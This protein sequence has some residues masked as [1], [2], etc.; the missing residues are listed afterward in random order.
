MT[1]RWVKRSLAAMLFSLYVASASALVITKTNSDFL[2]VD[3]SSATASVDFL[4]ADFLGGLD[5]I[6]KVVILVDFAKCDDPALTATS[7]TCIGQGN[8]FND[9]IVFSLIS[10]LGTTVALV[11]NDLTY[12]GQSPGARVQVQFD[13]DALVMVGG[14]ELLSGTFRPEGFLADFIDES[15]L[16]TWRL[17]IED[18]ASSD[19]LAYFGFRLD[20]TVDDPVPVPA[21][22]SL[23]LLLIGLPFLY[24]IR[25]FNPVENS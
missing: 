11:K 23:P 21:P 19:P 24:L 25:R 9:E 8:S 4:A 6:N 5:A 13:D 16:G 22:G 12:T 7:M 3:G 14:D 2:S 15:A 10:P 18:T 1:S 20:I 17:F